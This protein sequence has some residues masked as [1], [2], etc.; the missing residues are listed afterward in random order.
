MKQR[1]SGRWY[2]FAALTVVNA[3]FGTVGAV[4]GTA[5]AGQVG[6]AFLMAGLCWVFMVIERRM[7][8]RR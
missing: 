7:A 4:K 2:T 5:T 3:G 6:V 1:P 8:G